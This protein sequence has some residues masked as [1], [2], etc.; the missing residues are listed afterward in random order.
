MKE[1][2]DCLSGL[3]ADRNVVEDRFTLDDGD[4]VLTLAE[5]RMATGQDPNSISVTDIDAL[6]VDSV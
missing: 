4:T 6:F 5:W 2:V 1:R 3:V